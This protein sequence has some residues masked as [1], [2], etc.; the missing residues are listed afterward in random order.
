M[1]R[2]LS[3]SSTHSFYE[4]AVPKLYTELTGDSLSAQ[5][6]LEASPAIHAMVYDNYL[7]P[8]NLTRIENPNLR[9]LILV[10]RGKPQTEDAIRNM[11]KGITPVGRLDEALSKIPEYDPNAIIPYAQPAWN[12]QHAILENGTIQPNGEA[13][14]IPEME[15]KVVSFSSDLHVYNEFPQHYLNEGLNNLGFP[16]NIHTE[17]YAFGN[18][19]KLENYTPPLGGGEVYEHNVHD[20]PLHNSAQ[21][22]RE[23]TYN[24]MSD[25]HKYVF[26]G[27][28]ATAA[29]GSVVAGIASAIEKK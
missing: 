18:D 9:K 8:A 3:L 10:L 4:S 11:Y 2:K 20:V 21:I 28:L 16:E 25:L 27:A 15:E 1:S 23:E 19:H 22:H 6:I 29:I 12:D 17:G 14:H 7:E 26:R 24:R 13:H 5:E